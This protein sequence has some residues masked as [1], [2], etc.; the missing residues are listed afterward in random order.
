VPGPLIALRWLRRIG[1]TVAMLVMAVVLALGNRPALAVAWGGAGLG[2]GL[3]QLVFRGEAER[4]LLRGGLQS[5]GCLLIPAGLASASTIDAWAHADDRAFWANG[6][7]SAAATMWAVAAR[8][9]S[10]RIVILAS[11][12]APAIVAALVGVRSGAPLPVGIMPWLTSVLLVCGTACLHARS[13]RVTWSRLGGHEGPAGS[14]TRIAGHWWLPSMGAMVATSLIAAAG[15]TAFGVPPFDPERVFALFTSYGRGPFVIILLGL[16]C[17]IMFIQWFW[18]VGCPSARPH[19]GSPPRP[20]ARPP[21]GILLAIGVLVLAAS[22]IGVARQWPLNQD[23][24]LTDQG[25]YLNYAR[26]LQESP[27]GTVADRNRMPLYPLAVA[28]VFDRRASVARQMSVA[29]AVGVAIAMLGT[30]GLG[31]WMWWRE[32]LLASLAMTSVVLSSIVMFKAPYAQADLLAF[33]LLLASAVACWRLLRAPSAVRGA[34]TGLLLGLAQLSKASAVA[35]LAVLLFVGL[36]GVLLPVRVSGIPRSKRRKLPVALAA[37][38]VIALLT[39]MPYAANSARRYGSPTYNVNSTYY[40]WY[41]SW[42]EAMR[43]TVGHG[44]EVGPAKLPADQIPSFARY[45]RTH[46]VGDAVTRLRAGFDRQYIRAEDSYGWLPLMELALLG[47]AVSLAFSGRGTLRKY[48]LAIA[49]G[50]MTT[51]AYAL[52]TSWWMVIAEGERFTLVLALPVLAL[53]TVIMARGGRTVWISGPNR[54][55]SLATLL[56][57]G[58]LGVTLIRLPWLIGDAGRIVG[59]L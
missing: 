21:V 25:A 48:R 7:A 57:G 56:L 30:A 46:D 24:G 10:L 41:D 58:H 33:F 17:L 40:L 59:G 28:M 4:V 31:L 47:A 37:A 27:S 43:G 53:C 29:K 6:V 19:R 32:G 38:V 54:S 44:D 50:G 3:V 16:L 42:E 12:T 1:P 45:R 13:L 5:I 39:V 51:L 26:Q 55:V 11:L 22:V 15:V 18:S 8:R 35:M 23:P 20:E 49:F 2:W 34:F 9:R 52:S 14:N 36:M